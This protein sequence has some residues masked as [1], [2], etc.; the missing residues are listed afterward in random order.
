MTMIREKVKKLTLDFRA[1]IFKALISWVWSWIFSLILGSLF[2]KVD[3]E[4]FSLSTKLRAKASWLRRFC[5]CSLAIKYSC[6]NFFCC[7]ISLSSRNCCSSFGAVWFVTT[8]SFKSS[9]LVGADLAVL[10]FKLFVLSVILTSHQRNL[11]P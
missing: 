4:A 6:S 1:S 11:F 10:S 2:F 3:C 8:S 9:P 7:C 5:A